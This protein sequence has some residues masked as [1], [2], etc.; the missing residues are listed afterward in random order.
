M[1]FVAGDHGGVDDTRRQQR[2]FAGVGWHA[3]DEKLLD[4]SGQVAEVRE[5]SV[6]LQVELA[7]LDSAV[8]APADL[9]A[10]RPPVPSPILR[11]RLAG[12]YKS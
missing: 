12:F 5:G 3:G 8:P 11:A 6:I 7:A 2:A 1:V 10:F 9:G 4:V